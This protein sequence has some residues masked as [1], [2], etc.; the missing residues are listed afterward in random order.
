LTTEEAVLMDP[1]TCG[2][3]G[4]ITRWNHNRRPYARVY[5]PN[6]IWRG[7]LPPMAIA[8]LERFGNIVRPLGGGIYVLN[9]VID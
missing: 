4:H 1:S 8:E 6:S 7:Y 9:E 3:L 2:L 5:P